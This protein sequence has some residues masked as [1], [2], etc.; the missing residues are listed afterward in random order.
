MELLIKKVRKN[1]MI[2]ERGTEWSAGYDLSACI[3]NDIELKPSE[4]VKIPIGIAVS[5]TERNV[6]IFVF[7]RSGLASKHGITLA[8]SVGVVDSDYRGEI[9]VP[10]INN[11]KEIFYITPGM[12]IAQMVIMP[13]IVPDIRITEQLDA[14]DRGQNGFGSTGI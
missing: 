8:N 12:R 6:G 11:G 3:E 13:I 5:P 1:A 4:I 7:S 10:L 2:P 9:I 14:T